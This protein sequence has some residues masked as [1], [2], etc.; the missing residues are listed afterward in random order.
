MSSDETFKT[1]VIGGGQAGL[2]AGYYLTQRGEKYIILDENTRTGESWRRRWDSLHLF[3]PSQN[4]NLPGMKFPK[5][6][7]F[8]PTKEEAADYLEAY[9]RYFTLPV[10]YGVKVD[11]LQRNE[12]G[13]RL[14][15]GE[16][17]FHARNVIVATGAFHTPYKPTLAQELDPAIFQ[18]HSA[19]YRNA[20]DVPVQNVV[21]VGAGNSG[22]E[23]AIEL[24][25]AGKQ[26]W[27]AGRDVGRIPADK[28]GKLFGGKPYQAAP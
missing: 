21:M 27:L 10:R 20:K 7:F 8:F 9:A 13:Y 6:D 25:K 24:T 15:V 28:L 22:A 1:I 16:T 3:T 23:I 18:I 17:S 19:D 4:N 26:V 11:G 12:A 2:A 5:P 14:S